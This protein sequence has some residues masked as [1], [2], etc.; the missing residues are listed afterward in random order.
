MIVYFS[1]Y[2]QQ[3]QGHSPVS[4]GLDVAA[5][6]ASYALATTVAGHLV[7]RVGERM[8]LVAGL[9]VAGGATLGL[10]RLDVATGIGSMW[11]N[12]AA[13]GASIGLCGTPMS[14]IAMSA[15]DT[16]R[17]GMASA[18]VNSLRLVGQVFG[19]A[20]LGALVHAPLG[21]TGGGSHLSPHGVAVHRRTAPRPVAVGLGPD[22]SGSGVHPAALAGSGR[23]TP[24]PLPTREDF[25]M[26]DTRTLAATYFQAW[27]AKDFDTLRSLLADDVTFAGPFARLDNAE[28]C[29]D[30][31]R[32][33]SK[34]VTDLVVHKTFLDG[35]DVLTWF[36]LHTSVAAPVP[37]ANWSHAEDGKITRIQVV[38]DARSLSPPER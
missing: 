10:L 21:G 35:P 9:K 17:A 27:K 6:G 2:L 11:W 3:V 7:G 20:V 15:V 34:I 18:V 24:I 16:S 33:M 4:A 5:I 30:G 26:T 12:F 36:D 14:T 22:Q 1:S 19:V 29:I 23:R 32:G 25:H 28:D 13:L 8:P 31:L 37:T 38:F